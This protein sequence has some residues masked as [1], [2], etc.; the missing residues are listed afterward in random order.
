MKTD[1]QRL[2][3][4][5]LKHCLTGN[6]CTKRY[7]LSILG[8]VSYS[9]ACNG[10]TTRITTAPPTAR[11]AKN[12]TFIQIFYCFIQKITKMNPIK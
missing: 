1:N 2:F 6:K 9:L 8:K 7:K 11:A 3:S 12:V 5:I 4:F 10:L